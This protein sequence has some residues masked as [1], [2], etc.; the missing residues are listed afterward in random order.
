MALDRQTQRVLQQVQHLELQQSTSIIK[1]RLKNHNK[2]VL[3][4]STQSLVWTTTKLEK[5]SDRE[6][7][8]KFVYV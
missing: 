3:H 8:H 7:M 5:E 2:V 1:H 4:K 6:H